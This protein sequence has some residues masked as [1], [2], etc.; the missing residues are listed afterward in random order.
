MKVLVCGSRDWNDHEAVRL[1]L[2]RF[3]RGTQI[4]HGGCRGADRTAGTIANRLGLSVTE[5]PADWK[6][7]G[8]SAGFKW[9]LAMLDEKPD[10]VIAFWKNGSTGTAHTVREAQRRGIPTEVV[11]A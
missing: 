5:F 2:A 9:N 7:I 10:L 4:I 3:E 8:R 1:I 11:L 6:G